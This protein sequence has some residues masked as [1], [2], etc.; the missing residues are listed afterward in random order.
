[1][2]RPTLSVVSLATAIIALAS[3]C[4]VDRQFGPHGHGV[5]P[6][7]AGGCDG[8]GDEKC[9]GVG[10]IAQ[11]PFDH[12]TKGFGGGCG[13]VYWDEWISDPPYCCDPCDDHGNWVGT[14]CCP[15]WLKNGWRTLWGARHGGH[16]D[17]CGCETCATPHHGGCSSCGKGDPA[18]EGE[19]IY[20]GPVIEH[21]TGG[22]APTALRRTPASSTIISPPANAR[23]YYERRLQR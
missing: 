11:H 9:G 13:E 17:G 15:R 2:L 18:I 4:C 8:C 1:M 16:A 14:K 21:S 23:P 7:V 12:L 20:E 5:G 19:V 22:G 3:G 6:Y 10:H